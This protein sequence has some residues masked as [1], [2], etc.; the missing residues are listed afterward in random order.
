MHPTYLGWQQDWP[1]FVKMPFTANSKQWSKNE[2]FDWV[3]EGIN[4][5]DVSHLYSNGFIFHN[6]DLEVQSKVGDRIDEMTYTQLKTLINLLN[7]EVKTKTN[8]T[9]E[10]TSKKIKHSKIDQKQRAFVRSFLRHNR[11]IEDKFY[12]IRDDILKE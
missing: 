12:E 7:S 4:A 3:S 6:K 9:S 5:I 1:V 11:W 2:H 8:S 10:Y